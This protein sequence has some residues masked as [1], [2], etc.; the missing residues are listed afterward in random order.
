MADLIG[1]PKN[2]SND[3]EGRGDNLLVEDLGGECGGGSAAGWPP[4]EALWA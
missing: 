3:A 1:D 4:R 2:G